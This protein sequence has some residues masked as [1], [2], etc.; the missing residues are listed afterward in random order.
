MTEGFILETRNLTVGYGRKPVVS[1]VDMALR[2][3]EITAVAGENGC[4]KS[5]LLKTLGG[6]IPPLSGTMEAMGQDITGLSAKERA[7][8]M[9]IVMTR[10]VRPDYFTCHDMVSSGRY[11][12]T[13]RLGTLSD[14]DLDIVEEAMEITGTRDIKD[15]YMSEISD[16]QRQL[17]M[18]SRAIAQEPKILL[19]DEPTN[20]LDIKHKKLFAD[21]VKR[22]V[23]Q[24]EMTVIMSMHE[25]DIVKETADRVMTIKNGGILKQGKTSDIL[26]DAF[27]AELFDLSH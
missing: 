21:V 16:G 9:A 25:L 13:G 23:S 14:H 24:G 27:I 7:K 3:G 26:T 18:L 17:V 19:L 5:T 6:A 10:A 1:G 15:R 11:P 8:L 2:A 12:Y 20:F 22:L 4:G